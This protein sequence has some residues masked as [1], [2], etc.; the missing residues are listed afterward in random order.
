MIKRRIFLALLAIKLAIVCGLA[1]ASEVSASATGARF[2]AA[3]LE[4]CPLWTEVAGDDVKRREQITQVYTRIAKYPA[5]TIRAGVALFLQR[6]PALNFKYLDA[7]QK[8][9]ALVRVIF[10]VPQRFNTATQ[11]LPYMLSGNP[12]HS[13]GVD[14]AWPYSTSTTGQLVLSGVDTG[15]HNG[16]PYDPLFDFDQMASRLE[17]RFP[18]E[19]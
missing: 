15:I 4:E 1:A 9:F 12:M 19:R 14:L 13:D 16:P 17:R 3:E 11:A 2:I 10:I 6:Y 8:I 5:E 18:S 7:G